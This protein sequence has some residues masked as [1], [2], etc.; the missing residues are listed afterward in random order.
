LPDTIKFTAALVQLTSRGDKAENIAVTAGYIRE[1]AARGADFV[2]TPENTSLLEPNTRLLFEKSC[3]EAEDPALA[4]F[5]ALA[6]ELKIWL[7][8]GSL[9]FRTGSEKLANRS[10]LLTPEGKIAARYDKIHMFDVDLPNG[11]VYRE[12]KNFQPGSEAVLVKTPWGPMGLTICYDIRFPHL[13]RTYAEAG[14]SFLT[15]PAAFTKVTGEAHWHVL[16]RARAIETGCYMFAPAQYGDH[17]GGRVTYGHSLIVD[18][19]GKVLADGGAGNSVIMAEID[20]AEV[21]AARRKIPSL[22][23]ASTFKLVK[24]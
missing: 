1:A 7:L 20:P 13:Y 23:N 12:S 16:L 15:A 22:K 11:E 3:A 6:A 18:P 19:W 5:Q 21:T 24:L 10:I 4:A 2:M 8:I 14:A 17:G 9:A